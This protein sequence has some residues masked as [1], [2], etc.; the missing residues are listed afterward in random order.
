MITNTYIGRN[1]QNF[2]KQPSV[3]V[4][5]VIVKVDDEN[6]YYSPSGLTQAQWDAM[7]GKIVTV[8]IPFGTQAMADSI[9]ANLS[10]KAFIPYKASFTELDPAAELG[11]WITADGIYSVIAKRTFNLNSLGSSDVSAETE[12]E[13]TDKYPYLSKAE[14]EVQ[15]SLAGMSSRLTVAEGEIEGK[16]DSSNLNTLIGQYIDTQAGTAK[17]V[18]AC[19]ATYLTQ[20]NAS[21]TYLSK[22]AAA[23]TYVPAN[24]LDTKIGQYIDTQAGTAKVVFACSGTYLTQTDAI[25]TYTTLGRTAEIVS[26]ISEDEAKIALVVTTSGQTSTVNSASIVSAINSSGS[27]VIISADKINLTGYLTISAGDQRYDASGSA[28]TAVSGLETDLYNGQTTI[29]GGCITTGTVSANRVGA[30]TFDMGSGYGYVGRGSGNNGSSS[31]SGVVLSSYSSG[32]S[33][34]GLGDYYFIATDGGV[35]MT[36]GNS[37]VYCLDNRVVVCGGNGVDVYFNSDGVVPYRD[38]L[39]ALGYSDYSWLVG[40]AYSWAEVSD[41][42]KKENISYDVSAYEALFDKLKPCK[43]NYISDDEVKLTKTGFIAQ[44][45]E[46]AMID[47]GMPMKEFDGLRFDYDET[48]QKKSNYSLCYNDLMCLAVNEIQKLKARVTEL[49]ANLN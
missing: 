44:D 20:T 45:I 23:N 40:Y 31:T 15:M 47:I 33:Y 10:S 16:V 38:R 3:T 7:T 17:I 21:N 9:R 25:N 39:G 37:Y 18:S 42:D 2:E 13:V 6:N 4:D 11:D 24:T 8:S 12:N 29:N 43:F 41:R 34:L 36:G 5:R 22:T 26:Q 27:S 46:Q 30:G 32:S 49:E 19:S 1:A 35:R 48:T 28:S 14:A